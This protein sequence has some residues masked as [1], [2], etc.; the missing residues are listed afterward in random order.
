MNTYKFSVKDS[1]FPQTFNGEIE[2]ESMEA[3]K[4]ELIDWYTYELGTDEE[5]L[6]ITI[7]LV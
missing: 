4:L 7:E 5:S 6:V 2:A 1:F 3:A